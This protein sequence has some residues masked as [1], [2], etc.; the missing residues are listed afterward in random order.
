MNP[1]D[2]FEKE[3]MQNIKRL[4]KDKALW[5]KTFDWI[6]A[7]SEY[8]Y[9][10]N[11]NW[12]GRPVIQFP[13]DLIA[14][15]ELIWKTQPDL[16]IETGIAHGGSIIFYASILELL[17]GDGKVVGIDVDIRE[18]NRREIESHPQYKRITM[19]EGSS[20]DPEVVRRVGEM[21]EQAERV[22]VVLDSN[23]THE[24][25]LAELEAYAPMVRSGGYV[26]VFD[27]LIEFMPPELFQDCSWQPGDNPW[28]A[29]QTFLK[30]N[31]RF[32]IDK[33]IDA[34]LLVTVALDGYLKCIKD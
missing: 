29:V 1:A 12:L 34:K 4:A 13:Q 31:D 26:V 7:T 11:F 28:T 10:Y 8:K 15:Q 23:H 21:A 22:L 19:I 20:I 30:S 9:T 6:A 32:C 33:D 14:M 16:I 2:A 5:Q 25:V 27:T 24:H 3:K 18:H 17:G